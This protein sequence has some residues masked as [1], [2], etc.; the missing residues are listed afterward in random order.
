M[1]RFFDIVLETYLPHLAKGEMLEDVDGSLMQ[2]YCPYIDSEVELEPYF[3][4]KSREK[5]P[6]AE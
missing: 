6:L 4:D 2:R 3:R 1:R 5:T